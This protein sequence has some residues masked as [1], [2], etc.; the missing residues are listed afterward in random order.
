MSIVGYEKSGVPADF[1]NQLIIDRL[2]SQGINTIGD[3][4]K[5]RGAQSRYAA[6]VRLV[7]SDAADDILNRLA[8]RQCT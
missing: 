1:R 6:L 7:G 8:I 4:D 2:K 5:W 3:L